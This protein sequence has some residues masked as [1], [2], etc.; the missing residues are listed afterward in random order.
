MNLTGRSG[1]R[2]VSAGRPVSGHHTRTGTQYFNLRVEVGLN[3]TP[4]TH[5]GITSATEIISVAPSDTPRA[6]G[7][8]FPGTGKM[9]VSRAYSLWRAD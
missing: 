5:A 4:H 6:R 1:R 8:H 7:R 3:G 2:P 9:E